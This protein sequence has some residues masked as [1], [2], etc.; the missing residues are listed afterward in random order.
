MPNEDEVQGVQRE[1][2][3]AFI[4]RVQQVA[5]DEGSTANNREADILVR[6]TLKALGDVVA[7]C[8]YFSIQNAFGLVPVYRKERVGHNPKDP[9]ATVTIPA[10]W[11]YK[12]KL[13][14]AL[15]DRL[16]A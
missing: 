9:G 2:L 3:D 14:R 7:E 4:K 10:G 6:A 13:S 1:T 12:I 16:N 15:K 8:K 11:K 5:K